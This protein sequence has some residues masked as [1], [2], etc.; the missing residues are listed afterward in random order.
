MMSTTTAGIVN[1]GDAMTMNGGVG[2]NKCGEATYPLKEG[3]THLGK[4]ES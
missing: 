1:G 3:A 4:K 2:D